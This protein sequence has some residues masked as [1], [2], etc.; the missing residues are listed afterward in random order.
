VQTSFIVGQPATSANLVISE[1][2]YNPIASPAEALAGFTDQ[3]FEWIELMN[4][5]AGPVE[6]AGCRFDDGITFDFS[7]NSSVGTIAA[8]QR[9]IIASNAAAFAARHPG[10][11]IAG[12]FQ[13]SSNFSNSGERIELLA[14]DGTHILDFTYD[15]AAPWPT[16]PDGG[17]YS[18]VLINPAGNPDPSMGSNWRASSVPGGSPG[19]TDADSYSAWATRH[20][21]PGGMTSDPDG[22]G[23]T[24][25]AE[26][27]LGLLPQADET[28]G[29]Y[30]A[31]FEDVNVA[32]TVGTYLVLRFRH[33][34]LADDVSV[35]PQMSTDMVNWTP[36]VDTVPPPTSNPDGTED[37]ACR[38]PLPVT[39]GSRVYVRVNVTTR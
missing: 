14:A 37:L 29:I 19:G 35:I 3:M 27:G 16:S 39:A 28:D 22:N 21:I 10:V 12:T 5:S 4:I 15:D 23:L 38:S 17:G 36:L 31:K 2:N 1:F 30:S 24:N 25:L 33:N 7:A 26:Y 11:P 32:G 18:L 9:I 6:L 8:G 13:N 20:G 34:A